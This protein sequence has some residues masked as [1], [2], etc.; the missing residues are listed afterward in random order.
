MLKDVTIA[1]IYTK[2]DSQVLCKVQIDLA[3]KIVAYR[4]SPNADPWTNEKQATARM[5]FLKTVTTCTVCTQWATSS[6]FFFRR[7]CEILAVITLC[8]QVRVYIFIALWSI[9][10]FIHVYVVNEYFV[11][12]GDLHVILSHCSFHRKSYFFKSCQLWTAFNF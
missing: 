1:T 3:V 6:S 7:N 10:Q 2:M 11:T 12:Q 4:V 5:A 8:H 9:W